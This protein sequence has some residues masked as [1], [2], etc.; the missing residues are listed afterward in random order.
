MFGFNVMLWAGDRYNAVVW[1]PTREKA[2][3]I[4]EL[5]KNIS[6]DVPPKIERCG[7]A[8]LRTIDYHRSNG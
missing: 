6:G 2:E 5:I 7:N 3:E 4:L 8:T 1:C